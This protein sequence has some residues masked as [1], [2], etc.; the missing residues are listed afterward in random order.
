[1][2]TLEIHPD[3]RP[4]LEAASLDTFDALFAAGQRGRVDGHRERSVS[5]LELA[6]PDG[7]T[8]V[9]YVKRQWGAA[10]R[11][12][13]KDFMEFRWP[14]LPAEREWRN[15]RNL[16]AA[17]VAVAPPVA[18]GRSTGPAEPRSLIVFREVK[19][20][21]LAAWLH[22][23]DEGGA[24]PPP[25]LRRAVAESIGKAVQRLH[26]CGLSFPD[27]YAKHIFLE[28]LE[29]GQPRAVLIDV[30]RLR[31]LTR[32][33]RPEDFGAL[34][35][36][37]RLL[38]VRRSDRLRV[39]KA[40][41]GDAFRSLAGAVPRFVRAVERRAERVEG[42][43]QDPNLIPARRTAAPGMVPSAD[44]QMVEADGGRVKI[45]QAFL[46]T[47]QAAG[48]TTLDAIMAF[49]GGRSYRRVAGRSTVRVELADPRGGTRALYIKRYTRVPPTEQL[50][51]AL[52]LNPPVSL[53]YREFG[54]LRRVMDAG[55]AAM[56]W[57]AV[58]EA[59][60]RGGRAEHSYFITEE[61]GGATP[62]DVYGE[63]T[64]AGHRSPAATAAK[65]RLVRQIA[66][67]ARKFHDARLT[68]RDFYLCHILVR[69]MEGAEPVLH[70]ID[71]QRVVHH[72]RGVRSRWIV[73]DLAA[74]WFSS[75][76]SPATSLRSPVFARTDAV[77]FAREYF[78]VARLT[79][80]HQ[81]F[82]RRVARKAR[83]IAR[84]DARHR[85]RRGGAP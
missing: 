56:R 7:R 79:D 67:L 14:M 81:A 53:A 37:T 43:G 35:A 51:R 41:F 36:T 70:L 77:R 13:W 85:R 63:R 45:N 31:R 29:S 2:A 19:G 24:A 33:R 72:K 40:Y 15:A 82:L 62:A 66:R 49:Q 64:F 47:L 12:P 39:L 17:G 20:P 34:L 50:R 26:G 74:L 84:H 10:A 25:R 80:A 46:A 54:S 5:R 32:S 48:L 3:Y 60:A 68:H 16:L 65:R 21:S 27:L 42:R 59:I 28:N 69:P 4:L 9:L 58:G 52:S 6:G 18:W 76:P 71:L 73:K 30:S 23:M 1:M 22:A 44:E 38:A 75:Q 8:V 57:A 78:G 61:V 55:I 11:P 83:A